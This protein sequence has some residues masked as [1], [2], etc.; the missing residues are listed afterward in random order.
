MVVAANAALLWSGSWGTSLL[1]PAVLVVYHGLL[2]VGFA[3]FTLARLL[4]PL[5]PWTSLWQDRSAD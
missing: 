5:K 4:K 1:S 2:F 3:R